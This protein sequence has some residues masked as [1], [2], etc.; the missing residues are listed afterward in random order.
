M[1]PAFMGRSVG[2]WIMIAVC[3]ASSDCRAPAGKTC[4]D[5]PIC[6]SPLSP[7]FSWR[8]WR[9]LSERAPAAVLPRKTG[10][11]EETSILLGISS[12]R[13]IREGSDFA[14]ACLRN[15]RRLRDA[16]V[17]PVPTTSQPRTDQAEKMPG[18]V[19]RPS[20]RQLGVFTNSRAEPIFQQSVHQCESNLPLGSLAS[21]R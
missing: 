16:G 1:S 2:S 4:Q 5:V 13:P 6:R 20:A 14:S 9:P 8:I 7:A 11:E 12:L 18:G 3:A 21:L 10:L 17:L 15:S 19:K